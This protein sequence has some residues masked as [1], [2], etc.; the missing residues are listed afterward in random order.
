MERI[1]RD[2]S[3]AAAD[4]QEAALSRHAGKLHLAILDQ[5]PASLADLSA[6]LDFIERTNGLDGDDLLPLMLADVARLSGRRDH[7]PLP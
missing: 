5:P 1:E 4:E 2:T 3:I 6:K 7:G